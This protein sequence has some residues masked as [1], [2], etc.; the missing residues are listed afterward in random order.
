[1]SPLIEREGTFGAYVKRG[2]V[3]E[4]G[5][6]KLATVILEFTITEDM[7]DFLAGTG[8]AIDISEEDLFITAFNYIEKKKKNK[9]GDVI[10]TELNH[11]AIDNLKEVFGWD[12]TNPFW[13]EEDDIKNI[14]VQIVVEF[15]TY[16]GVTRPKV[17]W[18]NR[19]GSQPGAA[20]MD[21]KSRKG[22][23]SRLGSKL[24][25]YSGGTSAA[26]KVPGKAAEEM[27]NK[28]AETTNEKPDLPK[29]PGKKKASK[30]KASKNKADA[31]PPT[32]DDVWKKFNEIYPNKDSEEIESLWFDMIEQ[33]VGKSDIN[34]ITSTEWMKIDGVVDGIANPPF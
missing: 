3:N 7:A 10:G 15:D 19:F 34:D 23:T 21:E 6:H 2:T 18:I 16:N 24:R 12:G 32:A 14:A 30:K 8:E 11:F 17:R 4:I 31:P 1:M 33:A 20:P 26:P 9:D 28:T 22:V 29:P 27:E 5:D 13:F 25:A